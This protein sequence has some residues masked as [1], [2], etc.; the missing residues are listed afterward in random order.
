MN[1][2]NE[3]WVKKS[4]GKNMISYLK[5][6]MK[7]KEEYHT[8]RRVSYQKKNWLG[9]SDM[10]YYTML[11]YFFYIFQVGGVSLTHVTDWE[12]GYVKDICATAAGEVAV[13]VGGPE[14]CMCDREGKTVT[15]YD[16]LC[17]CNTQF[18]YISELIAGQYLAASCSV[19]NTV[20]VV[21]TRTHEVVTVYSGGDTGCK[22]DV[23]C[24]AGEGS[25]LIWDGK[26]K[27]VIHLKWLE[28]NKV[29]DEVRRVQV[30]GDPVCHMC[31]MPHADLLI[32]RR[33]RTVV[34]AVKLQG[35]AG[36]P[37]VWQLQGEVLGKMIEPRGVSCDSEGQVYV[38]DYR[39]S[40]VLLV[41]VYTGEVIQQL[42]QD[43]G[44]GKYVSRVCCLSDPHQLLVYAYGKESMYLY[45][46]DTL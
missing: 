12:M 17:R 1:R 33:G 43:A 44:L 3:G 40:R 36:Q 19:C 34:Q 28:E 37:P 26:S 24:T 9:L 7:P 31:Y 41:N 29:L 15:T 30:P 6:G 38:A 16:K 27:S 46:I 13:R 5:K 21:D 22:L 35:G 45:N 4:M 42:L 32:L 14:I 20:N 8:K 23:M 25:L 2:P 18:K 11:C 39:K 10:F